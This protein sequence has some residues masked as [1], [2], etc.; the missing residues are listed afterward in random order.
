MKKLNSLS[1][2]FPFWNEEENVE[3]VVTKA[4]PVAEKIADKWEIIIVDDGSSDNS[5]NL[6]KQLAKKDN[7]V[8][9]FS[10]TRR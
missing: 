6:V 4:I 8:K 2:F 7:K 3:S 1:I 10:F 5:L 9:I